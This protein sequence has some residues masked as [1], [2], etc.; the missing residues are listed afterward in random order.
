MR[1]DEWREWGRRLLE[2]RGRR[3]DQ[4]KLLALALL[5]GMVGYAA[6]HPRALQAIAGGVGMFGMASSY[7]GPPTTF[8]RDTWVPTSGAAR[9]TGTSLY[10]AAVS[11]T[12]QNLTVLGTCVGCGSG[13]GGYTNPM[14]P[15][16][17]IPTDGTA[18]VGAP[19]TIL[20]NG[21]A[22]VTLASA[23][24]ITAAGQLGTGVVFGDSFTRANGTLNGTATQY[25]AGIWVSR[26]NDGQWLVQSNRAQV[27][28][29]NPPFNTGAS[30]VADTGSGDGYLEVTLQAWDVTKNGGLIFRSNAANTQWLHVAMGNTGV[31]EVYSVIGAP[32]S[33]AFT[34]VASVAGSYS[35]GDVAAVRYVG[36]AITVYKNGVSVL[37]TA[38]AI[39]TSNTYAGL[40]C[41]QSVNGGTKFSDLYGLGDSRSVT[42]SGGP[43]AWTLDKD[44]IASSGVVTLTDGAKFGPTGSTVTWSKMVSA[45]L[46]FPTHG[47]VDRAPLNVTVPGYTVIDHCQ[48]TPTVGNASTFPTCAFQGADTITIADWCFNGPDGLCNLSP[49]A[50]DYLITVWH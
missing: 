1:I 25:G 46:T 9:V 33:P 30:L 50:K 45:S 27:T 37:A 3:R 22:T 8:L 35:P 5:S 12:V 4:A 26:G 43:S 17:W 7:G 41:N 13:G 32:P 39:G 6:M 36:S 20:S 16:F 23:G 34:L 49:T 15:T 18:I 28:F 31:I 48:V 2:L 14:T 42:Y 10:I 40:W 29:S 21:T 44:G 47:P 19:L 24:T 11:T 38:S